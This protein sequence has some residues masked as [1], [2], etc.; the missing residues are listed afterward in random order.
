MQSLAKVAISCK[1]SPAQNSDDRLG[2]EFL[3]YVKESENVELHG[4]HDFFTDKRVG[5]VEVIPRHNETMNQTMTTSWKSLGLVEGL[6]R[7]I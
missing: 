4:N 5:G 3:F 1:M 7:W 2:A 6:E